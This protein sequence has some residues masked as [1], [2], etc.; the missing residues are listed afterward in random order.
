M[1]TMIIGEERKAFVVVES[2]LD[3]IACA[4]A[5]DIAGA[6]GLG[7]LEI[8][9]DAA[10][11]QILKGAVQIL[12]ALD[13][14]DTGGGKKA[15]ERAMIWWK[16]NFNDKCDRWP[17]P[18][19]KDPGEA[20]K[21]GIDLGKWIE[22]GLPPVL[23]PG[24]NEKVKAKEENNCQ[25][26]TN[27]ANHETNKANRETIEPSADT[28]PLLAEL[29]KLLRNNPGVTIINTPERYTV[30]RNDRYVGGRI[31]DLVMKE[32]TVR[33][34]ILTHPDTEIT[35]KNLLNKGGNACISMA[36]EG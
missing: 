13:Y 4:A 15:A 7:A 27:P 9:P 20:V 22:A 5:T 1:A 32:D 18:A 28:P 21:K 3:A 30:S 2:E 36:T 16:E 25:C 24:K 12:N 17:V 11:Y 6:I 8:K 34:Y 10:A 31:N 23:T 19:G 14:G 26:E 29:W 33:E 35:W